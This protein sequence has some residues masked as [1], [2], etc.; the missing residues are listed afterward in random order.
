[1][2]IPFIKMHAQGNDFILLDSDKVTMAEADYPGLARAVC[3]RHFGIG[4]DGLVVLHSIMG[5]SPYMAIYNADG[6]KPEMCGSALRCCCA[7]IAQLTGEK[8]ITI[9][10]DSGVL[11]G[12]IADANPL[13]VTVEIGKPELIKAA[14]ELLG[15]KGDYVSVGNP[16]FVIF[17]DQA[18]AQLTLENG[19]ALSEHP[20]FEAG[21]NIEFVK[22]IS[23]SEIRMWVW[24]RGV[25]ITL[26]CGTGATAVVFA[27]QYRGYLSDLV[28]VNLPGGYVT[29]SRLEDTF[30]LIG[31]VTYV[32]SG[33]YLWKA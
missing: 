31:E 13:L 32:A 6:T 28:K 2:N 24:E 26:A 20:A 15:F 9:R 8:V 4:A 27:G 10:T 25:G 12:S 3:D 19:K 18:D 5:K 30:F 33:E 29:L 7:W 1:M 11:R 14:F 17:S 22:V 23:P 16:H 21:A